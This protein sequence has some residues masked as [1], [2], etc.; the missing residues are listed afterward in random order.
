MK[1]RCLI[2]QEKQSGILNFLKNIIMIIWSMLRM[3]QKLLSKI[4]ELNKYLDELDSI[5]ISSLDDY[6]DSIEKKRACD[7]LLQ[8]LIEIVIDICY[9]LY[10]EK[11][12][13]VPGNED[14]VI[15]A[16][17]EKKVISKEIKDLI[18][19]LKGFRNILVHKYG[20][21]DDELVFENLTDNI[22]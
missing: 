9:L 14:S 18:M 22:G 2:Q 5:E 17:C 16:L 20:A 19:E 21:V 7:R 11:K 13:G 1:T 3:E 6:Q 15:G 12:M 4:D 10:K 8:V